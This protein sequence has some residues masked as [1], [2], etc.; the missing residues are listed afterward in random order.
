MPS[1]ILTFF[2]ALL[3]L[4]L[5]MSYTVCVVYG[6]IPSI[7]YIGC[8]EAGRRQVTLL[9]KNS[10]RVVE[11]DAWHLEALPHWRARESL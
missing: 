1:E 5:P 2:P 10:G 6:G 7:L 3:I 8:M 9:L 4:F 11:E